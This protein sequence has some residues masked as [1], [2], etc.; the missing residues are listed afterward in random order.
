MAKLKPIAFLSYAHIDNL[1]D[2]G[3]VVE[4]G[5]RLSTE[6]LVQTTR[7]FDV[8]VDRN[9]I[10][11]GQNWR[12]RLEAAIDSSTF[13]IPILTPS[14]F[15]SKE[16]VNEVKL[17]LKREKQL[18]RDDLILPIYYI[19]SDLIERPSNRAE[20]K[21]A[22]TLAARQRADWRKLRFELSTS[23]QTGQK[24]AELALHIIDALSRKK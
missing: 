24:L 2:N 8:L 6:M 14:F 4:I 7:Q 22:T 11:W 10:K 18:K 1:Q 23:P 17:F 20:S 9:I 13:L 12:N 5:T 3:R 21:L 16:C 19:N 15:A